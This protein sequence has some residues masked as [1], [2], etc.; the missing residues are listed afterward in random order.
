M[1]S[2]TEFAYDLNFPKKQFAPK[3]SWK[4]PV[5]TDH[6]RKESDVVVFVPGSL[7]AELKEFKLYFS[8]DTGDY[9]TPYVIPAS[10]LVSARRRWLQ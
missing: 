2:A 10:C 8:S 6:M 1:R 5:A 7:L 4:D 3:V 9:L